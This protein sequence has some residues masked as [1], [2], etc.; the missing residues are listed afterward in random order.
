MKNK[1]CSSVVITLTGAN[2]VF[3]EKTWSNIITMKW[4]ELV[5]LVAPS[6]PESYGHIRINFLPHTEQNVS[7]GFWPSGM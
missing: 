6:K 2:D 4:T 7:R 5:M 3:G 1:R